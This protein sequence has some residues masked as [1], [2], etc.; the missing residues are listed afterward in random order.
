MTFLLLLL[1]G[2]IPFNA[3]CEYTGGQAGKGATLTAFGCVT[4]GNTALD[5]SGNMQILMAAYDEAGQFLWTDSFYQGQSSEILAVQPWS[6]GLLFTGSWSDPSTGSNALAY[7]V[8]PDC[9]KIWSYSL[10]LDGLDRFTTAAQGSDGT[11]VCAGRTNSF[12]AGGCDVLMVALD[13]SG[14]ELWRKV[15]GTPGEEAAYHISAC[16]DGGYV[17][18]CQ[19]MSWG[20]GLG[21]YWIIRT[22][23]AGDTLWTGTYGGPEFEYP[24]RVEQCGDNF[25]VAG[26]TLSYGAGSYDWW[27]LKLDSSGN[28]I[29][30]TAWGFKNTDNCMALT[31]RNGEA[32]VGGASESVL[33]QFEATIVVFDEEGTSTEEWYYEPAMIRSIETLENNGFLV[34]G[35][36][37]GSDSDLWA[38]CTDSLGNSPELG[39]SYDVPSPG[40]TL[41]GNP[42]SMSV[43]IRVLDDSSTITISDISGRIAATVQVSSETSILDV[44]NLPAGIYSVLSSNGGVTRMA[45]LR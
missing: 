25:Y 31:V 11:I 23:N 24:W 28:M 43:E 13:Q 16:S 45:V 10:E 39:I 29:W 37:Y 33:N 34:G 7:A 27:I 18:A 6:G 3:S 5:A 41:L 26:N 8:S 1:T 21:D 4:A 44:S 19:A 22:D 17:L 38:M 42:V 2:L 40:I 15:Y 9:Q 14:T 32:V 36:L 20:P 12:G 30:D 35:V